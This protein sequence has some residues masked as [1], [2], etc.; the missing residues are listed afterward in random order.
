MRL[1][2][3][4]CMLALTGSTFR[5]ASAED[6]DF[7]QHRRQQSGVGGPRSEQRPQQSARF[8]TF[9]Q[10]ALSQGGRATATRGY[11][12]SAGGGHVAPN[13]YGTRNGQNPSYRRFNNETQAPPLGS[14]NDV[15]AQM[16][17]LQAQQNA[18]LKAGQAAW[19]QGQR[20]AEAKAQAQ[21]AQLDAQAQQDQARQQAYQQ[22]LAQTYQQSQAAADARARAQQLQLQ[23][24]AKAD[25]D[26]QNSYQQSL[27]QANARTAAQ[28]VSTRSAVATLPPSRTALSQNVPLAGTLTTSALVPAKVSS[29][30]AGSPNL[31][32]ASTVTASRS[33]SK[34]YTTA[35]Y[36]SAFVQALPNEAASGSKQFAVGTAQGL[37]AAGN[38]VLAFGQTVEKT[39]AYVATQPTAAARS[40]QQFGT[41]ARSAVSQAVQHP[42]QTITTAATGFVQTSIQTYQGVTTALQTQDA[43][44]L[45]RPLGQTIGSAIVLD[46]TG[47]AIQAV[48]VTGQ[49]ADA[50]GFVQAETSSAKFANDAKLTDHFQK[51]GADFSSNSPA[52]YESQASAFLTGTRRTGVLEKV[53]P[54]GDLVRYDPNT[55]EFGVISKDGTIRTYFMPTDPNYFYEQ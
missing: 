43:G 40:L 46:G 26:R 24:Q 54:N 31:Q 37:A 22:Q 2:L 21:Q 32:N 50:S 4:A 29:Q 9:P 38:G 28:Q 16:R 18:Q 53:R 33:G 36:T 52:H 1:V 48:G 7:G 25:Q 12:Y 17:A 5:A 14:L 13:L 42:Q 41:A 47:K 39:D 11:G 3:F 30:G 19:Q 34:P 49:A 35:A 27:A 20:D 51:H 15:A 8:E 45:T 23:A 6:Q 10:P 55:N 44:T